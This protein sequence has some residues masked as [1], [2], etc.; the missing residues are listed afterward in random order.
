MSDSAIYHSL[1][2]GSGERL[3]WIILGDPRFGIGKK[4]QGGRSTPV[5]RA[6][7]SELQFDRELCGART[8]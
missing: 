5:W 7:P 1:R 4:R 6:M 3:P 2:I 8:A